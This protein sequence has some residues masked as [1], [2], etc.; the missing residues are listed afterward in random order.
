MRQQLLVSAALAIGLT[1][2]ALAA[3]VETLEPARPDEQRIARQC[4][5]DLQAF[6]QQLLE[7]EFGV[8][9]PGGMAGSPNEAGSHPVLLYTMPGAP[10]A[11]TWTGLRIS[12]GAAAVEAGITDGAV[13]DLSGS[14][15]APTGLPGS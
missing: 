8:L 7:A 11:A 2:T 12:I 4:L 14:Y 3:D 6:D 5:E 13:I 1:A 15:Q 10:V 9:P